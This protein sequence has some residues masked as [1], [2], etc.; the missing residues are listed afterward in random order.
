MPPFINMRSH[1]YWER[2][3]QW[4]RGGRSWIELPP[5]E[6][7]NIP[8]HPITIRQ[9]GSCFSSLSYRQ[10]LLIWTIYKIRERF[11]LDE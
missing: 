8:R 4:K 11:G 10:P 9:L 6:E 1:A 3:M 5:Q 7:I 2:Q